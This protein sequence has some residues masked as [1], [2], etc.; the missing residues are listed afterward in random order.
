MLL[1]GFV[2][3]SVLQ[4]S[5]ERSRVREYAIGESDQIPSPDGLELEEPKL[6]VT[7]LMPTCRKFITSS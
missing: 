3:V 2:V 6:N 7:I 4:L 5:Q 1:L